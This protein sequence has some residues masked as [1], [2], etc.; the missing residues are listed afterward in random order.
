MNN[1]G[2]RVSLPGFDVKTANPEQSAIDSKYDTFKVNHH[3]D[4]PHSGLLRITFNNNPASG[5]ITNIFSMSH[6]YSHRPSLMTHFDTGPNF[7]AGQIIKGHVRLNPPG[8]A[9]IECYVTDKELR[10][11]VRGGGGTDF[12]GASLG[13]YPSVMTIRY[14]IFSED[15][16]QK[17]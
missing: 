3:T 8:T 16:A 2:I 1:F 12:T 14:D 13:N 9:W 7:S 10:V 15:G 6:E 4:S 5:V 11:D 17:V